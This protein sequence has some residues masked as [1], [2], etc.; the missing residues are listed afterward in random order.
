MQ[1]PFD[2]SQQQTAAAEASRK[3]RFENF[4]LH[5]PFS[6][7]FFRIINLILNACTLA[8]AGHIRRQEQVANVIGVI[9]TSTLFVLVIAPIAILH[10]F[11]TLYV[12]SL[13]FP[14][15]RKCFADSFAPNR[16]NISVLQSV[17]GRFEQR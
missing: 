6:P 15:C 5:N 10:I 1:D 2:I 3:T 12:R 4:I 14:S 9:G 7:L 16:L 11:I 8:L 13:C 17:S